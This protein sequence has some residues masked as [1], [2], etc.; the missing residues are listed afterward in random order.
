MKLEDLY[1]QR[2]GVA[3]EKVERL[4]PAGSN[5]QYFRMEGVENVVGVIGTSIDENKAF[6][7]LSNH[8]RTLGL[9][10]PE[11]YAMSSDFLMYLQEDLGDTS[12][13]SLRNDM[14]L[15]KATIERLPDFQFAGSVNLDFSKCYPVAEFD[16]QAILWDLNYFKYCFLNTTHLSYREDLLE[17]EFNLMAERLSRNPQGTFMYRDFQ[18]RNVMIKDGKPFFIDFQ[19]GRRGPYEYDVVS[20]LWQAKAAFPKN[21]K[22]E[23]IDVYI[24]AASKYIKLDE[25][26]FKSNLREFV[27]LRT[28]QVLGAYGFRG[29]FE[30]KSHFLQSIPYALANLESLLEEPFEI[31][32]YLTSVLRMML[33]AENKGL[34]DGI[35]KDRSNLTVTVTS[36]SYKKGIPADNSGNGGGFV[37]DCRGMENPGRYAEYKAISGLANRGFT[38]LMVNFGCTGG[39]HRSV[40]S[41]QHFAEHIKSKF[42]HVNVHLIHRE[43]NIDTIL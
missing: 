33:D 24:K 14:S 8:F 16:R 28:L 26:E 2:Y 1:I 30:R 21:V 29:R 3:P 36:F 18:S 22:D 13:F 42:S 41:A 37:F 35:G 7:Y 5:R 4:T 27:L 32:P 31:Y 10:V 6:I 19:G 17:K 25:Q 38:S 9:P 20:F 40:Y 15:L 43:Q 23:L 11:V 34:S 39:Q 12:L